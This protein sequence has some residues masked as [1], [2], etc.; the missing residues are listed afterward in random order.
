MR[1]GE[2]GKGAFSWNLR[3]L[4]HFACALCSETKNKTKIKEREKTLREQKNEE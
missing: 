1:Q 4:A 3:Y 2:E